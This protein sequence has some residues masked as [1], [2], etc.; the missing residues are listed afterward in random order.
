MK[1]AAQDDLAICSAIL[2][3]IMSWQ[4]LDSAADVLSLDADPS[5]LDGLL[6]AQGITL[7]QSIDESD[8][9]WSVVTK[10]DAC[11]VLSP[12]DLKAWTFE[13]LH[14]L[15]PG[16]LLVLGGTVPE[17]TSFYRDEAYASPEAVAQIPHDAGFARACVISPDLNPSDRS[18]YS[19]LYGA[20]TKF[21]VVAQSDAF[22]KA[23]DVFSPGFLQLSALSVPRRFKLAEE[24]LHARIHSSEV[25]LNKRVTQWE[26]V[27]SH[28]QATLRD[29][30]K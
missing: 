3:L 2:P 25:G 21:A 22:G 24:E 8:D 27:L 14:R 26:G 4:D 15:K 30:E 19:A 17:H 13:T 12:D 28:A 20:S 9:D 7:R 1:P 11:D 23:F 5:E 18:L 10:L 6:A 29:Q 16:G